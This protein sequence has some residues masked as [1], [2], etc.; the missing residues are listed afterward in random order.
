M[1]TKET[2]ANNGEKNSS[3]SS[4]VKNISLMGGEYPRS[5]AATLA[6]NCG[7]DIDGDSADPLRSGKDMATIKTG[8]NS[9]EE[10]FPRS[11][12]VMKISLKGEGAPA[13]PIG[14]IGVK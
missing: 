14:V 13:E 4:V 7:S 12:T 6:L 10:N 5:P 3:R 2:G 1:T 8:D 11:G 9:A